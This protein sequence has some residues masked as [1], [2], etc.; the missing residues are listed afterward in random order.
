MLTMTTNLADTS[1][2]YVIFVPPLSKTVDFITDRVMKNHSTC[3]RNEASVLTI[4]VRAL[5]ECSMTPTVVRSS[6]P[7]LV[8]SESC[9]SKL[10][11]VGKHMVISTW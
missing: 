5:R 2:N 9:K 6:P 11:S 7:P 10:S 3:T 1:Y 8:P 4:L